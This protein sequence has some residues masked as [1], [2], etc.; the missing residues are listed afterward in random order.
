MAEG[1]GSDWLSSAHT[2][3]LGE[4]DDSTGSVGMDLG[5][6]WFTCIDW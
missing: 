1:K 2:G 3:V 6:R 5:F 4:S